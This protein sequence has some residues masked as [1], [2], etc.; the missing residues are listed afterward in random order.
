MGWIV[1]GAVV[2]IGLLGFFGSRREPRTALGSDA[3]KRVPASSSTQS[4]ANE[5]VNPVTEAE[6][7]LAYGRK[8]QAIEILEEA[9]RANPARED[10]RKKLQEIKTG[11]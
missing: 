9:L 7:Y 10:V 3:N 11:K 5:D 6:V 4:D 1:V 8:E 2:I